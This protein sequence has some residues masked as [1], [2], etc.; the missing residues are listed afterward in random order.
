MSKLI[1]HPKKTQPIA[2]NPSTDMKV[3]DCIKVKPGVK[4][5]N[6]GFDIGGWQGRVTEIETYQPPQVMIMFQWDSL[7]LERMPASAIRRSY[8][9]LAFH[10]RLLLLFYEQD[11]QLA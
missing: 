8:D 1:R 5:P 10:L 6:Y 2:Q 4:D 7:S 9:G 3:G 11:G